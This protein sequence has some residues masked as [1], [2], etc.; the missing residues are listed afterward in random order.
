MPFSVGDSE[1]QKADCIFN[2]GGKQ[3]VLVNTNL[4]IAS[5]KKS[6]ACSASNCSIVLDFDSTQNIQ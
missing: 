4:A 3:L 2:S 1:D 6:K 5:I